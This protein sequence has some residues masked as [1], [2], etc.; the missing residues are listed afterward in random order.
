MGMKVTNKKTNMKKKTLINQVPYIIEVAVIK[1]LKVVLKREALKNHLLLKKGTHQAAV[2]RAQECNNTI[3]HLENKES[4]VTSEKAREVVT[5]Q[6]AVVVVEEEIH[7]IK[8]TIK[9]TSKQ[10]ITTTTNTWVVEQV[11]TKESTERITIMI[12]NTVLVKS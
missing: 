1:L 10:M 12:I 6:E 11:R 7:K 9:T 8:V 3:S 5:L 2:E 4:K